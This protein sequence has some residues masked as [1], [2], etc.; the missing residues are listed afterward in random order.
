MFSAQNWFGAAG[1]ANV[2]GIVADFGPLDAADGAQFHGLVFALG[3]DF[4]RGHWQVLCIFARRNF[5]AAASTANDRR[6]NGEAGT[7][8]EFFI[9]KFEDALGEV[10]GGEAEVLDEFPGI[11]GNAETILTPTMESCNGR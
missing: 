1:L 7:G 3:A 6:L 9:Q 5:G 4:V 11:S 2:R 8:G 10:F